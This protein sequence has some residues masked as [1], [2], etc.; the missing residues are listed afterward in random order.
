MR[1]ELEIRHSL[2]LFVD[3]VIVLNGCSNVKQ[4]RSPRRTLTYHVV[5]SLGNWQIGSPY[6]QA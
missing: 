2:R 4:R 1:F 6:K 3:I 5:Q